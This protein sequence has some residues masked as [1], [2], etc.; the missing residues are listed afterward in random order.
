MSEGRKRK[1]SESPE[2][3]LGERK[4]PPLP[5]LPGDVDFIVFTHPSLPCNNSRLQD[6]GGN[7]IQYAI[8]RMRLTMDDDGTPNVA[9]AEWD[10]LMSDDSIAEWAMQYRLRDR[11]RYG[12]D[13]ASRVDKPTEIANLFKAYAGAVDKELGPTKLVNWIAALVKSPFTFES[14]RTPPLADHHRTQHA[15]DRQHTERPGG[16]IAVVNEA[17]QQH[18]LV[19]MYKASSTGPAHSLTW[20]M[21]CNIDGIVRGTGNGPS[22][23]SAKEE[24]ARD[25]CRIMGWNTEQYGYKAE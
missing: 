1:L 13:A 23:Q 18:R 21:K 11:L 4:D 17:C 15:D 8:S 16:F 20:T 25:T 14:T 24:A 2:I 10:S 19:V 6:I 5:K 12:P 22:K 3:V 9:K 7:A